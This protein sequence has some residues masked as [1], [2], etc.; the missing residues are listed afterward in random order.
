MAVAR[1]EAVVPTPLRQ[2]RARLEEPRSERATRSSGLSPRRQR[3]P[4]WLQHGERA[5]MVF[6]P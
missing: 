3:L 2:G 4:P 5:V 6:N 1:A